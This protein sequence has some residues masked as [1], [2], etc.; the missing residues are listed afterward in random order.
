MAQSTM[1]LQQMRKVAGADA[2]R[3][4]PELPADLDDRRAPKPAGE[5]DI[6]LI[7]AVT[8]VGVALLFFAFLSLVE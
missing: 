7:A 6:L 4:L 3:R 8:F 2:S 5:T 1:Q